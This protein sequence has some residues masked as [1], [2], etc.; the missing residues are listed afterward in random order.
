MP[1]AT[2]DCR[3]NGRHTWRT[4]VILGNACML[5][6]VQP[7][8]PNPLFL[9]P[10]NNATCDSTWCW[11]CWSNYCTSCTAV[12]ELVVKAH[13]MG[14]DPT[15]A[16]HSWRARHQSWLCFC[17][18]AFG[19]TIQRA[20]QHVQHTQRAN[21]GCNVRARC[22]CCD[23]WWSEY[24]ALCCKVP[25][26]ASG[27]RTKHIITC[28]CRYVCFGTRDLLFSGISESSK[29]R[30]VLAIDQQWKERQPV[31]KVERCFRDPFPDNQLTSMRGPQ[32]LGAKLDWILVEQIRD[33][34]FFDVISMSS[35]VNNNS[36]P[37]EQLP[38]DHKWLNVVLKIED[39]TIVDLDSAV[40]SDSSE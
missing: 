11:A 24:S 17:S 9:D 36:L 38:S 1:S 20:T 34:S 26:V 30:E 16:R 27:A 28:T 22:S 7:K 2:K 18:S 25:P 15:F 3:T 12:S 39:V 10:R 33:S 31:Y 32:C 5:A 21:R 37:I 8:C 40:E 6:T 19:Q 14:R 23:W 13:P 35:Q 4:Q 29:F